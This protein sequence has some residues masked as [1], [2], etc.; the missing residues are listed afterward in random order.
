MLLFLSITL[1]QTISI[2]SRIP[3]DPETSFECMLL[4]KRAIVNSGVWAVPYAATEFVP[5]SSIPSTE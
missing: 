1:A 3:Q 2:P 5:F 4:L